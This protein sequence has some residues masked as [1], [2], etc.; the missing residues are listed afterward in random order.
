MMLSAENRKLWKQFQ[1]KWNEDKVKNM[2][3]QEYHTSGGKDSCFAYWIEH[4]LDFLGRIRVVDCIRY[5]I[6]N[7]VNNRQKK[8]PLICDEDGYAWYKRYGDTKE[9]AFENI[10]SQIL[11]IIECVKNDKISDIDSI[12]CGGDIYKWKIAFCYQDMDNP[13]IIPI[14][15]EEVL[16][17]IV[18][19]ECKKDSDKMTM[20]QMYEE[21]IKKKP[22]SLDIFSWELWNKYGEDSKA[23][24]SSNDDVQSNEKKLESIPLN[25]IL[26]GPP[27]T[28]KTYQTID[29]AFEILNYDDKKIKIE[30]ESLEIAIS[31]ND[32][33]NKKILFDHLAKQ[34]QI[35][36]ITFHQ[37]YGYEEFIEGIKPVID[38]YSGNNEIKQGINYQVVDGVFKRICMEAKKN[39]TKPYILII[40]EI[41][42]G[43]ISKIFGEL[44]TLIEPSKRIGNDEELSLTLPYSGE[45][46]GVPKNL[47][48]IGTM[49]T[50][51]RSIAL[52]DT[53]LR[54]RF[55]FIEMIPKPEL[56]KDK[57]IEEVNLQEMLE[58]MNERIE[59]LYDREH[60]IGHAFF[61]DIET[62][63]DLKKVFQN[64]IIPLLQEYFYEDYAKINAVLNGNEMIEK[65]KIEPRNI[66]LNTEII[67]NLDLEDKE[68]YKIASFKEKIWDESST[69]STILNQA[70]NKETNK[71][72]QSQ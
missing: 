27:G 8:D 69:Y 49:N 17:K 50:A 48:I 60:T 52:M 55:D 12:D 39:S 40:D 59:F 38:E 61:M 29:K 42:R 70:A 57:D 56:L 54:R 22:R 36:F 32:R 18:K 9:D 15:K 51:D 64:K 66:F 62:L 28:G 53:A 31:D 1:E 20:S 26:Y 2:T 41:N 47:Y 44:I 72:E 7:K 14:Y 5:G 10:K 43:N 21:I 35:K 45:S 19:Q 24:S 13:K 23:E 46:F 65:K 11:K 33:K 58:A 16:R 67:K 71:D 34:G 37:S 25:Q 68:S 4:G 3:L 63:T 6:Y 30:L